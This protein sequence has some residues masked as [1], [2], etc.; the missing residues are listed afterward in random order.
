M[1]L[2]VCEKILRAVIPYS[3]GLIIDGNNS[4]SYSKMAAHLFAECSLYGKHLYMD[5]LIYSHYWP[6]RDDCNPLFSQHHC[7]L[8]CS[9]QLAF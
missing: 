2:E 1:A 3:V 7:K 6:L 8:A 4:L 9:S 5:S